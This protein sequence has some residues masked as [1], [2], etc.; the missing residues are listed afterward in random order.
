[1]GDKIVKS[2]NLCCQPVVFPSL[3]LLTNIIAKATFTRGMIFWLDLKVALFWIRPATEQIQT[4]AKFIR[5]SHWRHTMVDGAKFW[6]S[7][8]QPKL[9]RRASQWQ[10]IQNSVK[11][12]I[13][14]RQCDNQI[15]PEYT[16]SSPP[17]ETYSFLISW[18]SWKAVF[19]CL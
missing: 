10:P 12:S 16:L 8:Q 7:C 4:R 5:M 1:M 2:K 18:L 19:L 6:I 3:S 13:V 15:A 9:L 11:S 14:W 17:K